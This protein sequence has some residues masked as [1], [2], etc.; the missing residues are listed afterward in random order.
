MSFA[1]CVD[2]AVV[3]AGA[4]GLAAARMLATQ[5]FSVLLLEARDRVGGRA[6]TRQLPGGFS[7]DVGCEWLH[8]ANQNSLVPIARGLGFELAHEQPHWG[9]Q[10]FNINFPICE[11]AEFHAALEAFEQRIEATAGL[12]EDRSAAHCLEPGDPWNSLIDAVS[13]YVNGAEL[14]DVSVQDTSR[15]CDTQVDWRVR[16]GYGALIAALGSGIDLALATQVLRIDHS[17]HEIVLATS[18]GNVRALRVVCTVPTDLIA[19]E[20]LRFWPPLPRKIAA[21]AALPLGHAEK[22]ML[23][24][25]NF[26]MLPVDGH[27]FGATNRAQTGSYDLRPFGWPCIQAFFGGELARELARESAL[28]GYATDELAGLF[29]NDFR[30]GLRGAAA[31]NWAYDRFSC[32]SYS[33]ARIGH[34]SSR[35]ELALPVDNRIFFAGEATSPT[36]FSTAHG[37]YDSG[38]R[39]AAEVMRSF[40]RSMQRVGQLPEC[41]AAAAYSSF[42]TGFLPPETGAPKGA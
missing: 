39:S 36:F 25:D 13:T 4:A 24:V 32:G 8:S 35:A 29:G 10:S 34:A 1:S 31:S 20:A 6:L 9:E 7:F 16:R 12:P 2:V 5:G 41:A 42:G 15:Y 30:T 26:E 18:R 22:A 19:D 23:Y 14:K 21:A 27:L 17:G 37:A 40:P 38:L 28:I 11:Q 33:H 3:G